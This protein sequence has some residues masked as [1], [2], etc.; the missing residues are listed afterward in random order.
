MTLKTKEAALQKSNAYQKMLKR[1]QVLPSYQYREK[2]I[3]AIENNPVRTGRSQRR[4]W[5]KGGR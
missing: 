3:S 1:R 2:I 5:P 4:L